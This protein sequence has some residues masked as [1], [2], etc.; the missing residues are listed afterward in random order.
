MHSFN[1]P[2]LRDYPGKYITNVN[3]A[4]IVHFPRFD[5]HVLLIGETHDSYSSEDRFWKD[6]VTQVA[7]SIS[8]TTHKLHVYHE[9]EAKFDLVGGDVRHSLHS[10]FHI[11]SALQDEGLVELH[12]WDPRDWSVLRLGKEKEA[13][14]NHLT[15]E[16]VSDSLHTYVRDQ[17]SHFLT[18]ADHQVYDTKIKTY[19]QDVLDNVLDIYDRIVL[20]PEIKSRITIDDLKGVLCNDH[21]CH[22]Y[23]VYQNALSDIYMF[24]LL[25]ESE[26]SYSFVY[27]GVHHIEG[28]AKLLKYFARVTKASCVT[29]EMM[30][31]PF[32]FNSGDA[33][34][35]AQELLRGRLGGPQGDEEQVNKQA[36]ERAKK[37]ERERERERPRLTE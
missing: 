27:G 12:C 21:T 30:D 24:Y 9:C 7:T 37:R 36:G 13:L 5:W 15:H 29:T 1:M 2:T 6:F 34:K 4:S 14:V 3:R 32:A 31:K 28:L 25:L 23:N 10:M 17:R 33:D 19:M 22:A 18:D 26:H 16:R 8:K 35:V 11:C 20:P